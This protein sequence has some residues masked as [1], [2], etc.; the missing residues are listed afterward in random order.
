MPS[1]A[2][3]PSSRVQSSSS[4]LRQPQ[5]LSP[6]LRTDSPLGS[7]TKSRSQPSPRSVSMVL[8]DA[9]RWLRRNEGGSEAGSEGGSDKLAAKLARTISPEHRLLPADAARSWPHVAAARSPPPRPEEETPALRLQQRQ[10]QQERH[11]LLSQFEIGDRSR[12]EH[13]ATA[14]AVAAELQG[15]PEPAAGDGLEREL[16]RAQFIQ[17][18]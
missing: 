16:R 7:P 18:R 2:L 14:T 8:H 15:S 1:S 4:P 5:Q 13:L 6:S 10:V 12:R 3:S 11:L 17:G 9:D